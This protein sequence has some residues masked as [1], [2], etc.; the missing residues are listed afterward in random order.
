MSHVLVENHQGLVVEAELTR[1]AG[2][3]ERLAVVDL[4]AARAG[5][6]LITVGADRAY[7]ATDFVMELRELGP[8]RMS[9]RTPRAGAR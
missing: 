2:F 3:A 4:V 1:A 9:P 7:D 5:P 6:G 8:P